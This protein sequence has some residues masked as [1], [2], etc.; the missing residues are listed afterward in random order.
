[1]KS[2]TATLVV[3]NGVTNADITLTWPALTVDENGGL[4]VTGY[5][6]QKDSGSETP[7]LEPGV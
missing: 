6:L 3:L 1:M 7:F 4:P 5:Y 2:P